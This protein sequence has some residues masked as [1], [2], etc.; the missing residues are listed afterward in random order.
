M[1]LLRYNM[2]ENFRG[3]FSNNDVKYLGNNTQD[4]SRTVIVVFVFVSGFM[5]RKNKGI[6]SLLDG[7]TPEDKLLQKWK[8]YHQGQIIFFKVGYRGLKHGSSDMEVINESRRVVTNY[9]STNRWP[10]D[11]FEVS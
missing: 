2:I 4:S 3:H 7:K 9:R 10:V 5:Y 6:F 11:G 8:E 1:L